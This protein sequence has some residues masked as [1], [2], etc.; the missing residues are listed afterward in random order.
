MSENHTHT[1]RIDRP[2]RE[3]ELRIMKINQ[4]IHIF[5]SH[6]DRSGHNIKLIRC[7]EMVDEL[8]EHS[9]KEQEQGEG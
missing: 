6:K 5:L 9:L 8:H 2:D 7:Y 4:A 3:E 1:H